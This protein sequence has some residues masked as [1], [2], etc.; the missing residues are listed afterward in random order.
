MP[1]VPQGDEQIGKA[2]KEKLL[3]LGVVVYDPLQPAEMV[4][5]VSSHLDYMEGL[6]KETPGQAISADSI[7]QVAAQ[8]MD[9]KVTDRVVGSYDKIYTVKPEVIR[10]Q[11]SGAWS[12]YV[13]NVRQDAANGFVAQNDARI[14]HI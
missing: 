3:K 10:K 1:D 5:R 11:L 6:V 4:S 14:R 7:A 9:R 13:K 12:F 8:R 2:T